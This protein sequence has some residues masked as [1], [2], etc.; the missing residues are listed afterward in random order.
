MLKLFSLAY[1]GSTIGRLP[2]G[3]QMP[4]ITTKVLN[5]IKQKSTPYYIRDSRLTGFG[6][7]VS[8]SG[9]VKFIAETKYLGR[10]TRKTLG[11]HPILPV[12]EARAMA[13]KFIGEVRQGIATKKIKQQTL[14]QTLNKYLSCRKLKPSTIKSYRETVQFY[15]NDWLNKPMSQISKKMVE[16]RFFR[17]RDKGIGGGIPTLSQA[18]LCMR[19]LS[20]LMNY[21]L[22]DEIVASNPVEVLKLK[23]IDRSLKCRETYLPSSK[24]QELLEHTYSDRH[25]AVL[26]VHLMLYTGLRKNEA[27]SLKWSDIRDIEDISC[28]V[29]DNTKNHRKHVIPI[30]EQI[31][32]IL[33]KANNAT[34]FIFPSPINKDAH[35]RDERPTVKRLSTLIDFK[36]RCHDL[37]RTFATRATEIGI[38]YLMVKRLLNHKS[39]D[40]TSQYIQWHSRENLLVAKDALNRVTY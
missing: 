14:Q 27:L 21:C 13:I 1:H 36:F 39:N 4:V 5:S 11:S 25:P 6:V 9:S 30:T 32:K 3:A 38:D 8:P 19:Y 29:V 26:A 24:V 20:S 18:A 35:I 33:N 23:R 7:K 22:A 10:S 16:E 37:R 12:S 15:L 17:I 31:H 28:I 2:K 40:I 34:Q